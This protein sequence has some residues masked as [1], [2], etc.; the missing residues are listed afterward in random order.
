MT[1]EEIRCCIE[2][3]AA[4]AVDVFGPQLEAQADASG[5]RKTHETGGSV[6]G[7]VRPGRVRMHV[8]RP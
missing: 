6:H 8:E 2:V 5:Y 7:Q 1:S 3:P 4:C